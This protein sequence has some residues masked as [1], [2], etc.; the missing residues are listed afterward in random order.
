MRFP[1]WMQMCSKCTSHKLRN[2]EPLV[3]QGLGPW[4]RPSC[5]RGLVAGLR[6]STWHWGR[7]QA[8]SWVSQEN[9]QNVRG[10]EQ[11]Q[12]AAGLPPALLLW[13]GGPEKA[14]RCPGHLGS[15]GAQATPPRLS[16]LR[17]GLFL[18]SG[19]ELSARSWYVARSCYLLKEM[20]K[21]KLLS[22]ERIWGLSSQQGLRN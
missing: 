12:E 21:V 7:A 3:P 5:P 14:L 1:P 19:E 8:P 10:G 18:G 6:T 16:H 13:N 15:L 22:R 20:E 9:L 17:P 4:P 11:A 2:D